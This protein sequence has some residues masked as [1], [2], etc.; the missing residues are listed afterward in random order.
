MKRPVTNP[1]QPDLCIGLLH[2]EPARGI[3]RCVP[4]SMLTRLDIEGH[5][6]APVARF[7]LRTYPLVDFV[8]A[9][10]NLLACVSRW[11]LGHVC[12]LVTTG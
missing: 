10:G 6:L 12:L 5:N 11:F 9:P 4:E 1:D 7:Y 2:A 3:D 8:T